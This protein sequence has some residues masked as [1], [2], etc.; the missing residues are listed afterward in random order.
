MLG[1]QTSSSLGGSNSQISPCIWPAAFKKNIRRPRTIES[2]AKQIS[3]P[4]HGEL[5]SYAA[6]KKEAKQSEPPKFK[7]T[8]AICYD[9]LLLRLLHQLMA[10]CGCKPPSGH[11]FE[12]AASMSS[13]DTPGT[14][15]TAQVF[16]MDLWPMG[17]PV[18]GLTLLSIENPSLLWL[19]NIA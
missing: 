8:S 7:E 3:S 2:T 13:F 1:L 18:C 17:T 6:T 12:M 11:A 4:T 19:H 10:V 15:F 16:R 14:S 5:I 9:L